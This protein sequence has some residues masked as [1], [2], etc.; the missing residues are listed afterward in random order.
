LEKVSRFVIIILCLQTSLSFIR[1]QAETSC[2]MTSSK[3]KTQW[4]QS[5][6]TQPRWKTWRG[7]QITHSCDQAFTVLLRCRK[8]IIEY[9][10]RFQKRV[11]QY[12]LRGQILA[13]YSSLLN[14]L[15]DFLEVR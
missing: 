4:Q 11:M 3:R 12:S 5:S 1:L 15:E 6:G 7:F 10:E 8:L 14:L 9:C 13:Y 2:W